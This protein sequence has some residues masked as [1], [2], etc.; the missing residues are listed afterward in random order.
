MGDSGNLIAIVIPSLNPDHNLVSLVAGLRKK[1]DN[2]IIIVND[3]SSSAYN[4]LF[5]QLSRNENVAI[6]R[7][8]VNCGKGRACKTAF[9]HYLNTYPEGLGVVTCDADGQHGVEDILLGIRELSSHPDSL[10]LGCRKFSPQKVPWKS[11]FGNT[12]TKYVY[13]LCTLKLL[14]DTQTGLRG[15]PRDFLK[16]LLTVDGERF[17]Y[18][19]RM[20][21]ESAA[22][23]IPIIE[24]PIE[25]IYIDS[26]RETHF[27][28]IKDS[29]IIYLMIFRYVFR[30]IFFFSCSGLLSALIDISFFHLFFHFV[31]A[32]FRAAFQLGYA[33]VGA[34]VISLTFNYI[35]NR[36]WVFHNLQIRKR[37][38]FP[39]FLILCCMVLSFA[40][41]FNWW[42]QKLF[43]NLEPTIIKTVVDG[44]LFFFS[45]FMQ[46]NI[47][48]RNPFS[49]NGRNPNV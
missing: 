10:I 41:I 9:N 16:Y 44:M 25:T 29:L 21:L 23:R 5:D 8:A 3:G 27:R 34:R 28:P 22:F 13:A 33:L 11:F 39:K 7:H 43:P 4:A 47:I 1:C 31:F 2:P 15:I 35:L 32:S 26:N 12:I 45:F 6:L 36:N 40:Y 37:E 18:E 38:T 49:L 14:S 24:Y 30:K 19:T 17:E 20:L 46:K 48:F 42:G